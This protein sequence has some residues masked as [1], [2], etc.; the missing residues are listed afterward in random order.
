[1]AALN[2]IWDVV[3]FGAGPAGAMTALLLGRAGIKVLLVDKDKF[4]RMK[5]CGC[6]LSPKSIRE[7]EAENLGNLLNQE[8]AIPL[9]KF[10]WRTAG[11]SATLPLQGAVS[12][13]RKRLDSALIGQAQNQGVTFL[14]QTKAHIEKMDEECV[15]VGLHSPEGKQTVHAK[16]VVFATGLNRQV[17][18]ENQPRNFVVANHSRMGIASILDCGGHSFSTHS[19]H[20]ASSA[21][22]YCGMVHLENGSLN[23]AAALTSKAVHRAKKLSHVVRNILL[24]SGF[25][26]PAGLDTA[27]WRGTPALNCHRPDV[28]G[29]RYIVLGDAASYVEPFTGEGIFWALAQARQFVSLYRQHAFQWKAALIWEWQK[30]Y[31]H[32]MHQNSWACRSLSALLRSHF[33][34]KQ[35]V[36]ALKL[37]PGLAKPVMRTFYG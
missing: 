15:S 7:L 33:W 28:A 26:V 2:K 4:P 31:W 11:Q 29:P 17:F 12:L 13:S 25:D 34:S 8:G 14:H 21:D 35:T 23:I 9:T 36:S 3:I 27:E 22:G 37:F 16:L 6:C 24:C 32:F 18:S 10:I 19:I 30:Q 1:M 20:M 5:V